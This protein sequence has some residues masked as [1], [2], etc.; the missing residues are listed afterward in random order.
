MAFLFTY[1]A[2]FFPPWQS[3]DPFVL[4][5][6]TDVMVFA[7]LY[8]LGFYGLQKFSLTAFCELAPEHT[9]KIS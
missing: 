7:L 4:K 2:F 1:I 3:W 9:S 5:S 8:L 6:L